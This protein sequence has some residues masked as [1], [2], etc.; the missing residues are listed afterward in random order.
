M[1]TPLFIHPAQVEAEIIL[2]R[3]RL[4]HDWQQHPRRP[5]RA[6][7]LHLGVHLPIR[8]RRHA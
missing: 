1:S 8:A 2:R 3:E 5:R 4:S 6:H 7:R